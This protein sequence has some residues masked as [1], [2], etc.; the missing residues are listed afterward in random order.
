MLII[1]ITD[2][3]MERTNDPIKA[4]VKRVT[5]KDSVV[6]KY[7]IQIDKKIYPLS[8]EAITFRGARNNWGE[9]RPF[10][11]RLERYIEAEVDVSE[12]R[13]QSYAQGLFRVQNY[14]PEIYERI[15]PNVDQHI[16]FLNAHINLHI[17]FSL[18]ASLTTQWIDDVEESIEKKDFNSLIR[19]WSLFRLYIAKLILVEKEREYSIHDPQNILNGLSYSFS[20]LDTLLNSCITLERDE[21]MNIGLPPLYVTNWRKLKE[22]FEHY[23]KKLY[24]IVE[25]RNNRVEELLTLEGGGIDKFSNEVGKEAF[26]Q[27]LSDCKDLLSFRL[28]SIHER[29]DGAEKSSVEKEK[30]DDIIPSNIRPRIQRFYSDAKDLLSLEPDQEEL[31]E[32]KKQLGDYGEWNEGF[33]HEGMKTRRWQLAYFKLDKVLK[34]W[35]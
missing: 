3:D 28:Y 4:A 8:R 19:T 12:I 29:L 21:S 18:Q 30:L 17:D 20:R 24:K 23:K 31:K 35:K 33:C 32:I 11:L 27:I 25:D 7:S 10:V 26:Y 5:G 2:K 1:P 16:C 22:E 15:K 6:S 9:C 14:G 34:T 13:H